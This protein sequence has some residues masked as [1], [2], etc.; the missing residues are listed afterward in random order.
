VTGNA[1]L[2]YKELET[3]L[4]E[5]EGVLNSRP[6]TYVY[7]E[8]TEQPITPS[9]LVIGRRLMSQ[10]SLCKLDNKKNEGN[11]SKRA[12]YLEKLL[13]HFRGCWKKEYLTGIRE[14]QKLK[15]KIP[16]RGILSGDIVHIQQDKTPRLQWRMGRVTRLYPGRDGIIQSAE[17]ATLDPSKR[18]IHVKRPI[19]KLYPLEVRSETEIQKES[20]NEVQIKPVAD[21]DIPILVV[22]Q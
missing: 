4:I 1:K 14:H 18:V 19:E 2:S 12:R 6:L 10:P 16:S 17:V 15:T 8:I 22:G 21:E 7:D 11:L 9:C 3:T 5:I 13:D 20:S